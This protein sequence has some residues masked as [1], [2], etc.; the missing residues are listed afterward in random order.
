MVS[1]NKADIHIHTIFSDGLMSPEVLV[2]YAATQ[3][4]LRVIAVTDHDTMAGALVARAYHD[5]FAQDF[6]HLEVIVG[7]EITSKD[8]DILALFIDEDIPSGLSAAETVERIHAQGG[9]AVAAHPYAFAFSLLG[10]D[11]MKGTKHLIRQVTFDGV[12]ERNGTPTELFSNVWTHLQNR[13]SSRHAPTGGS[14]TH[15]MPTLGSTYTLFPGES[16]ADLRKAL[17]GKLTRAGG[18]VYSPLTIFSVIND[19]ISR[20]L[21]VNTNQAR[22]EKVWPPE[23]ESRG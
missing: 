13:G 1:W 6:A 8:G 5:Y 22:H 2:E 7:A 10:K 18:Y 3:T 17:E 19:L 14:D 11:G 15:Y 23:G 20:R 9:L 12:E 4:D 21:P 16:A